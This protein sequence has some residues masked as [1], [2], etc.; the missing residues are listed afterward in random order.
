[1]RAKTPPK[2]DAQ[3][4]LIDLLQKKYR[5]DPQGFRRYLPEVAQTLDSISHTTRPFKSPYG[6][7]E[8]E[9]MARK[10]SLEAVL[11]LVESGKA[12]PQEAVRGLEHCA[13]LTEDGDLPEDVGHETLLRLLRLAIGKAPGSFKRKEAVGMEGEENRDA[14]K[15]SAVVRGV[16]L[17]LTWDMRLVSISVSPHKVEE[18]RKMLVLVGVAQ[19]PQPDVARR[20]DDYLTEVGPHGAA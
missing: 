7:T 18:R 3:R 15:A 4:R 10:E 11:D 8:R 1:M 14:V 16:S 12:T 2:G 5:A 20:H 13:V 6:L 19:D 17:N 9:R